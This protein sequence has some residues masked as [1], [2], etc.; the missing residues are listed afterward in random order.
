MDFVAS[1][2]GNRVFG[3]AAAQVPDQRWLTEVAGET[4]GIDCRGRQ[5]RRVADCGWIRRFGVSLAGA[6]A[7]L[8][9]SPVPTKLLVSIHQ[10]VRA[11]RKSLDGILMTDF[12][13]IR[14]GIRR[15]WLPLCRK[16]S[17]R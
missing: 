13:G 4:N 7:G 16:S 14:S 3:M 12:T 15:R 8:A 5:L 1:R 2:A 17:H 11:L 10:M 6:V 9:G